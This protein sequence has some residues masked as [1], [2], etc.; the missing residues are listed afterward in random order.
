MKINSVFVAGGSGYVGSRLVPQLLEE[1][2]RVTVYDIM[3]FGDNFS[4][5][6]YRNLKIIKGD[7]RNTAKI[8]AACKHHDAFVNLACISNDSSFELD[9]KLSTSINFNAFKSVI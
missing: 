3:Y 1:G 4:S 9:E 5:K 7:I 6:S 2:Y 8:K